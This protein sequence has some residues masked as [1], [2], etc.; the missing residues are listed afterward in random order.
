LNTEFIILSTLFHF[1]LPH[2]NH[3]MHVRQD[4]R[5]RNTKEERAAGTRYRRRA[6][7]KASAQN[8]N[9][10]ETCPSE[11]GSPEKRPPEPGKISGNAKSA[12]KSLPHR[13]SHSTHQ[14]PGLSPD[15]LPAYL[16]IKRKIVKE[17]ENGTCIL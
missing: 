1:P 6:A 8:S 11:Y 5:K 10:Q 7:R 2:N 9:Q 14:P 13:Q 3:V 12:E 15:E 16:F 4:Q 17:E